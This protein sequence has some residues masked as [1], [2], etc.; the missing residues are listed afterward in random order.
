MGV[1]RVGQWLGS[2]RFTAPIA[3]RDHDKTSKNDGKPGFLTLAL[4]VHG[5]GTANFDAL[6][7]RAP[8]W[9]GDAPRRAMARVVLVYGVHRPPAS[10]QNLKQQLKT[11]CRLGASHPLARPVHA[12]T[13]R[14]PRRG[15][16]DGSVH[17]A[18]PLCYPTPQ[19]APMNL[20]T[21]GP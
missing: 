7:T 13:H 1:P 16:H 8:R 17:D 10:S 12:P 11:Q 21:P 14:R 2:Y 15:G 9:D 3:R 5:N 18:S 6:C 4:T 19:V 20:T